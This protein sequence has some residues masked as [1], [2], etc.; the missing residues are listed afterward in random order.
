MLEPESLANGAG[1]F[2]KQLGHV[3]TYAA[4][5]GCE[6]NANRELANLAAGLPSGMVVN[7]SLS[8]TA[9]NGAAGPRTQQCSCST[10][11]MESQMGGAT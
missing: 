9:V 11:C 3:I 5:N 2:F 10:R 8:K 6:I 7:G 1:D 4:K